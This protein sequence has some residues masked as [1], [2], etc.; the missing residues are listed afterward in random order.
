MPSAMQ[1]TISLINTCIKEIANM[2]SRALSVVKSAVCSP[3]TRPFRIA[4]GRA[5]KNAG[6]LI[7]VLD[8]ILIVIAESSVAMAPSTMS[9]I[10]KGLAMLLSTHPMVSPGIAAGVNAARTLSVS[11]KRN[12][13]PEYARPKAD[14]R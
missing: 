8:I 14:E 5:I 6:C 2:V 12:C 9:I 3:T 11:D 10:P 7:F 4:G 13:M 1:I